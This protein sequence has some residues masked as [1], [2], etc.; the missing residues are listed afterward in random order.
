[1]SWLKID[2]KLRT[3][4]KWLAIDIFERA[5]WFDASVWSAAYNSDGVIPEHMLHH[6]GAS[7]LVPADQLDRCVTKLC[8]VGWW[9]RRLKADGGGWEIANWLEY[10]P[11]KAQVQR[12]V[13]TESLHDWLHK[14]AVGKRVKA[15]VRRRDGDRCRYCGITCRTDG[16]RRSLERLTFDYVDPEFVFD[17]TTVLDPDQFAAVVAAWVVACGYHNACKGR[18]TPDDA[19]MPLLPAHTVRGIHSR[20]TAT[21]SR[22]DREV[23]TGRVGSGQDGA[24]QAVSGQGG[25]PPTPTHHPHTATTPQFSSLFRDPQRTDRP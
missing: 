16:D 5:L 6:I 11:S 15:A 14:S 10:Q 22:A 2:D 7:A 19:G 18:R 23:G 1:M 9:R 8:R 24:G 20:S 25:S 13:E 3:H 4:A 21:E 17:R 12:R